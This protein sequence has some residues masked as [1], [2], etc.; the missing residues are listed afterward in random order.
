M[1]YKTKIPAKK[2]VS[3]RLHSKKHAVHL[4]TTS[5][6]NIYAIFAGTVLFCTTTFWSILGARLHQHNA[7]QLVNSYLFDSQLTFQQAVLPGQHSF[8]LKWPFFFIIHLFGNTYSSFVALTVL[9]TLITIGVFA[10]ILWRIERRPVVLGTLLLMLASVLLLIPAQPYPG[11]LLPVNMAML[12]TRNLEYVLFI[13]CILGLVKSHIKS[14]YFMLSCV[15]LGL[16]IA[17]DK[18]FLSISLAGAIVACIVYGRRK[19]WSGVSHCAGWLVGTIIGGIGGIILLWLIKVANITNFSTQTSGPFSLI[20]T[21]HQFALGVIYGALA[22]LTNLGSNPAFTTT[23]FSQMPEDALQHLFS[24]AG[25]GLLINAGVLL[26][27]L[28][29]VYH[30]IRVSLGIYEKDD[31][32]QDSYFYLSIILIW[33]SAAT[34]AA[35]VLTNHYFAADARY[36]GISLFTAFITLATYNRSKNWPDKTLYYAGLVIVCA[37]TLAIPATINSYKQSKDA[38]SEMNRRNGLVA[39]ALESHSV[40]YLVGDYWRVVPTRQVSQNSIKIMPLGSCT[41]PRIDLSSLNWRPN[42]RSTSFAY[43][44]SLD[45]SATDFPQCNLA[46]VTT[47][48]GK[49]NS[50]VVISGSLEKP[51]EMLL[52]YDHGAHRSEPRSVIVDVSATTVPVALS[53][54]PDTTCLGKSI[55]NIV[56]HE[57]D[58]L[59]FINPDTQ[60]SIRAGNCVRTIYVTAGDSGSNKFYWLDREQGSEAAYSSMIGTDSIWIQRVIKLDNKRY[61]SIASP[62]GNPKI[63]L[64][65]IRLPDGN[66]FGDGFKASSY[67]S[68]EK[69]YANQIPSI[70]T[71]YGQSSF[72]TES[73]I[74]T[75]VKLLDV[76]KP[77]EIRTQSAYTNEHSQDH[78]DHKTVSHFADLAY[79]R[80]KT[81]AVGDTTLKH[82]RGYTVHNEPENVEGDALAAKTAA[83]FAYAA[84]DS[85]VC[86]TTQQCDHN[87]VYGNYLRRQYLEP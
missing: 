71:V 30:I 36:L 34:F 57:D 31:V 14:G 61:I 51:T 26:M 45:K 27:G 50:S 22:L 32:K 85:G 87:A 77:T 82:Y 84:H 41:Q 53:K 42:L 6:K 62:R 24:L 75:L 17:S 35:F 76:Y 72:T 83:F 4:T 63:S 23:Y 56:A 43:L 38:A 15:G 5:Y 73:L 59:L 65:F 48:Y 2:R 39:Q 12:A 37:I 9:A 33:T 52:F 78:S 66:L 79:E 46:D 28:V 80:Y 21:A 47:V 20:D 3:V 25:P 74:D 7:D 64:V 40:G 86:K 81:T 19:Q 11:A 8:L 54:L 44:L 70:E 49:P 68:L 10:F 67:N 18:L 55:M 16:L 69:L 60:T 1:A 58:D 13:V 29:A